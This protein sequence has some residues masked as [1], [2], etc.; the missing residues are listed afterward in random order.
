MKPASGASRLDS[1]AQFLGFGC[2]RGN[3]GREASEGE[4]DAE[5]HCVDAHYNLQS[6]HEI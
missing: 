3:Y 2:A 4:R 6:V 1:L 5:H